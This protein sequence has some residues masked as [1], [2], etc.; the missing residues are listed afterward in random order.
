M[1]KNIFLTS[2]L[3]L[4]ISL[5]LNAQKSCFCLK[6]SGSTP[7]VQNL[8]ETGCENPAYLQNSTSTLGAFITP[9]SNTITINPVSGGYTGNDISN[10]VTATIDFGNGTVFTDVV[11]NST[12]LSTTHSDTY[13]V[14]INTFEFFDGS[15][16]F[17]SDSGL[18]FF[19]PFT[20]LV[21]ND[22]GNYIMGYAYQEGIPEFTNSGNNCYVVR[23]RNYSTISINLLPASIDFVS[24]GVSGSFYVPDQ[25]AD[26]TSSPYKGSFGFI[27][28]VT[29]QGQT[30]IPQAATADYAVTCEGA[31]F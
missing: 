6:S 12:F 21:H 10:N 16:S 23:G 26:G 9:S 2:I 31:T 8:C 15:I 4:I 18:D 27:Q 14:P 13:T 28:Q 19:L 24:N 11:N 25:I 5:S 1:K 3:L 20:V 30:H 17:T 7:P 22:N 29:Y